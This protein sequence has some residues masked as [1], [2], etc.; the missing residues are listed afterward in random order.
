MSPPNPV[1]VGNVQ[2]G[3]NR[4]LALIAGPCVMEPGEMTLRIARRLV[5]ICGA[6]GVPLIFKASFDK[7]NRTSGSS[8]RGPGLVEGMKVFARV[9]AET[10]LP[11]TTDIHETIQ[12]RPLAEMVDLLQ[13]PA[14]LAR[15]TDLLEAAAG[16]GRP[17]NVKKGQFMAPWDMSNVVAKLTE[18]GASG[19]LLTERARRLAMA[20]WSTTSGRSPRCRRRARRWS[21]TPRIRSSFP[22]PGPAERPR[23]ASA[24]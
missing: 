16:T 12:A 3:R 1:T 6:L 18:S 19:V 14:F 15:Q 21:S 2:I 8:F 10:G 17:V 7:A 4:P 9:K 20:G 5:E 13:V 24:R 22:A 23:R 11:V